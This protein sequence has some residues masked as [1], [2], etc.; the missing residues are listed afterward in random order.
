MS[1]NI[2][3]WRYLIYFHK[4]WS[5]AFYVKVDKKGNTESHFRSN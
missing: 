1:L 2:A 4:G 5:S 3:R